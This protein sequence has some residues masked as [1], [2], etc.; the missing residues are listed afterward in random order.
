MIEIKIVGLKELQRALKKA[1]DRI[2][3]I[4]VQ[5]GDEVGYDVILS[6]VGLKSY[7]PETS[8]NQPPTPYYIRGRGTQLEDG[9][10][11]NSERLKTQFYVK[12]QPLKTYI[13]NQVSY[14]PYVVGDEQSKVMKYI[15]WRKLLDVALEKKEQIV[16]VYQGAVNYALKELG[17]K[18]K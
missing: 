9:N 12:S 18:V 10:L 13:G 7:P 8:A 14:A 2:K 15:G 11:Y 17:L 16:K 4:L 1:P 3:E 5:A 6:T